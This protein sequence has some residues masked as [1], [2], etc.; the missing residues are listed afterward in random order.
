[1]VY[2][3]GGFGVANWLYVLLSLMYENNPSKNDY[4]LVTKGYFLHL[5]RFQVLYA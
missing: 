2:F 1:M 5:L 3:S 4:G